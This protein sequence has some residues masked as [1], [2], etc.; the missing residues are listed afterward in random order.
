[1]LIK[2]DMDNEGNILFYGFKDSNLAIVAA[3]NEETSCFL[4]KDNLQE[5]L[6]AFYAADGTNIVEE[7][8]A[9]KSQKRFV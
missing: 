1:M 7:K 2:S 9:L 3:I 4:E 5:A 6:Q 8:W